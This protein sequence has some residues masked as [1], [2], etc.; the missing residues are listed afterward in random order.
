MRR[1]KLL[2]VNPISAFRVGLG[3]GA[4]VGIIAAIFYV[5]VSFIGGIADNGFFSGVGKGVVGIFIGIFLGAL[6]ML[7]TAVGC[8]LYSLIYN[9][10]SKFF[11][12]LE[13]EVSGD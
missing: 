13:I 10:T 1:L 2:K 7:G 8:L 5:F 3:I 12:S 4:V 6:Y 9:A 11:G